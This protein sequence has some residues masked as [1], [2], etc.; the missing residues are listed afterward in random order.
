MPEQ[1][2][3]TVLPERGKV[4]I[5]RGEIFVFLIGERRVSGEIEA[6]PTPV[7]VF[8]NE[9]AEVI[10]GNRER[11]RTAEHRGPAQLTPG[12]EAGE[13]DA[14]RLRVLH[15]SVNGLGGGDLRGGQ[16]VVRVRT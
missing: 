4:R 11:L 9:I 16:A 7:R 5:E 1:E 12:R 2:L 10:V 6:A 13:D 3:S 8:V 15:R 14:A